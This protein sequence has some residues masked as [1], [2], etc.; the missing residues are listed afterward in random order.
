MK[1]CIV[2]IPN[3]FNV[4]STSCR[5]GHKSINLKELKDVVKG[6]KNNKALSFDGVGVEFLKFNWNIIRKDY[7]HMFT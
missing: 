6:I 1:L 7:L 2:S 4:M 3:T 5:F